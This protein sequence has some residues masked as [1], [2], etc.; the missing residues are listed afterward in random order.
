VEILVIVLVAIIALFLALNLLTYALF[1]I[2]KSAAVA[3]GRR[4]P[5]SV[6]LQCAL[7]GGSPAAKLAQRRF[8]HKTRKQ[9]FARRLNA[10]VA[11][12]AALIVAALL[13]ASQT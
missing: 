3:A 2:D 4:V 9:P 7:L 8:R 13:F 12:Q 1:S 6:L 10:I 5:E 11:L